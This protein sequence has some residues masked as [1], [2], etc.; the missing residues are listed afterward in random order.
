MLH[1]SCAA[2]R[3]FWFRGVCIQVELA[4]CK[5][6]PDGEVVIIAQRFLGS[7]WVVPVFDPGR[8]IFGLNPEHKGG[9]YTART[10]TDVFKH[11]IFPY[12]ERTPTA[13]TFNPVPNTSGIWSHAANLGKATRHYWSADKLL[14][15]YLYINQNNN[16]KTTYIK[17]GSNTINS[18]DNTYA[19]TFS[20]SNL[21]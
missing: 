17:N 19:F 6:W 20:V 7:N 14:L 4:P 21:L 18:N 3:I 15:L 16:N 5:A 10:A 9:D 8:V 13:C 11:Q 1:P 2:Y 12:L